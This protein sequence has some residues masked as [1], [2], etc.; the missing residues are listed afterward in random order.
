MQFNSAV[1]KM[2]EFL[3]SEISDVKEWFRQEYS[4]I[5]V[6]VAVLIFLTGPLLKLLTAIVAILKL[7]LEILKLIF[8]KAKVKK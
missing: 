1:I 3:R 8:K 2:I 5:P 4:D 7:V 6:L